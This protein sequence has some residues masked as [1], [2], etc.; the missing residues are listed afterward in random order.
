M[1]LMKTACFLSTKRMISIFISISIGNWYYCIPFIQRGTITT[2]TTTAAAA[3]AAAAA[4]ATVVAVVVLKR[5]KARRRLT[6][7]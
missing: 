7:F 2:T 3:A 6:Y 5:A 4:C 1:T